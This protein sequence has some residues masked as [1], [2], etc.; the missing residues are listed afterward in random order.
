MPFFNKWSYAIARDARVGAVGLL[1]LLTGPLAWGLFAY[2]IYLIW[3]G[4][5]TNETNKWKILSE[6]MADGIVFKREKP[7]ELHDGNEGHTRCRWPVVPHQAVVYSVIGRSPPD[8]V[9]G[10]VA[11]DDTEWERCWRLGQL[12]NVYDLGFTEN[13]QEVLF[14]TEAMS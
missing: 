7:P 4:M 11:I 1:A 8:N 9:V 6:D 3:A 13:I 5:T 2:H 14:G 10:G 12:E